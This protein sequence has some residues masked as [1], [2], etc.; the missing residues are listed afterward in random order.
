MPDINLKR[1]LLRVSKVQ[2]FQ[3]LIDNR[4]LF[5]GTNLCN[6]GLEVTFLKL[7]GPF[8]EAS[9][10]QNFKIF[11]NANFDSLM[12]ENCSWVLIVQL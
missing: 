10:V 2:S 12:I 4:I 3:M 8:P 5:V 11:K 6:F 9:E 1:L 7:K